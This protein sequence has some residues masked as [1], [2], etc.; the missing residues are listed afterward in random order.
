MSQKVL[1]LMMTDRLQE[2]PHNSLRNTQNI[3]TV[4]QNFVPEEVPTRYNL[5]AVHIIFSENNTISLA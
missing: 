3:Y 4:G 2:W 5:S 1:K